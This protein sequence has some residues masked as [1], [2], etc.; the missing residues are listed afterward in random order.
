MKYLFIDIECSNCFNGVGKICEFGYVTTDVNFN[1]LQKEFIPMSPGK[2]R[3]NRFHLTGRKKQK[4]I[5]LAYD[6]NFYYSCPEFPKYYEKI[7]NIIREK[8]TLVFGYSVG[9]DIQYL[10]STIKKYK[11]EKLDFFAYDIQVFMKCLEKQKRLLG[12]EDALIE[13]GLENKLRN[14][15][16]HLSSDDAEMSMLLV[17]KLSKNIGISLG[18]IV[19][20][21]PK[22]KID[23]ISYSRDL[24]KKL[25]KKMVMSMWKNLCQK[26]L[27]LVKKKEST[28]KIVTIS[29][30]IKKD[31]KAL[32]KTIKTI[33]KRNLLA[34]N[35]IASSDFFIVYDQEDKLFLIEHLKTP[36]HGK[37]VC[38]KKF[39]RCKT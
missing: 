29:N 11:L 2:G 4:D 37:Y 20:K 26:N 21:Y 27:S 5:S 13:H 35:I 15:K 18:E 8:D 25:Q 6:E 1:I 16:E 10:Y 9:N 28:G 22:C 3:E 38:Y 34:S 36:Y 14:L 12:L 7:K 23:S 39:N 33:K 31:P 32:M 30:K 24:N 17:E 19:E